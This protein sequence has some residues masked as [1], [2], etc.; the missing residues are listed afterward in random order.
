VSSYIVLSEVSETIRRILWASFNADPVIRTIVP[1]E[2]AIVFSNPTET[3]R[4][5]AN[6]LSLWLYHVS[7]NEFVKNEPMVRTNGD[8]RFPPLALDFNYLVT[9]FGPTGTAD[10]MILGKTMQ[11]LY[12]NASTLLIDQANEV[13]EELHIILGR[14]SIEELAQLWEALIE[15]Y[16]LSVCYSVRVTRLDSE[17][18]V[19]AD[20]VLEREVHYGEL[21]STE[22][23]ES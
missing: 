19:Q 14:L 22:A 21:P 17:R 7:E 12:D 15:P 4:D 18:S 10:Q 13:W 6:R 11:V 23:G 20:K 8:L 2:S 3:A 9:P 16:R 1:A 5:P